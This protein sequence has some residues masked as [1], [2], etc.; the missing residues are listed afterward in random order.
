MIKWT[1]PSI[2]ISFDEGELTDYQEIYVTLEGN[3]GY[4]QTIKTPQVEN[5]TVSISLEQIETGCFSK[6]TKLQ[7][8][9]L[10]PNGIR[11]ASQIFEVNFTD[12]LYKEV[13]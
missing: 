3:N 7:V 6:K 2:E 13:M 9:V 5:D 1:T 12:N 10:F 8:N 4:Q 11:A